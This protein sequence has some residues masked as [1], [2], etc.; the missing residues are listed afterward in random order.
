MSQSSFLLQLLGILLFMKH[1]QRLATGH[2]DVGMYVFT[3]TAQSKQYEAWGE[4]YSQLA[5]RAI[6]AKKGMTPAELRR[7]KAE[8]YGLTPE[9]HH[10]MK[11]LFD[12]MENYKRKQ[13]TDQRSILVDTDTEHAA[14]H[15]KDNT[16]HVRDLEKSGYVVK[17]S[18][19]AHVPTPETVEYLQK[20]YLILTRFLGEWIPKTRF[21]LGE[22]RR[23]FD[24]R[25]AIA[26]QADNRLCAITIQKR[27][28]GET[29]KAMPQEEKL[30]PEVLE[31]LKAAHK[32]YVALK[33]LMQE[34]CREL[35]LP[36][37]VLDVKLDIGHLSKQE[38]LD[39]FDT[40][41]VK[42][43]VS[44]NIMY[45]RTAKKIRFIDFDM[46]DWNPDKEKVFQAIMRKNLV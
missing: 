4:G 7:L 15:G 31:D 45:D 32:K 44:P 9:E 2:K 37:N 25:K 6:E 16:V 17:Y 1:R 11:R 38:T 29:F 23:E 5:Q 19:P 42:F 39:E 26:P 3:N 34:T 27:V 13:R 22:R 28:R 8:G 40:E 18:T 43:F 10:E 14:G 36:E 33:H 20:K 35:G 30:K 21:V 41:R 46:N 24:A 12:L